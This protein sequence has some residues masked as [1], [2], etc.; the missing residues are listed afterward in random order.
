MF[1][2]NVKLCS[3]NTSFFERN[4]R[5]RDARVF[6]LLWATY[7]PFLS[8]QGQVGSQIKLSLALVL[9]NFAENLTQ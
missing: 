2:F 1:P 4:V 6:P 7:L 9:F 3:K 8:K 5:L